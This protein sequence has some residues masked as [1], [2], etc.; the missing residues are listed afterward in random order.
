MPTKATYFEKNTKNNEILFAQI[1]LVPQ[2][3]IY[4]CEIFKLSCSETTNINS[5]LIRYEGEFRN[6]LSQLT[7]EEVS[8]ETLDEL[9]FNNIQEKI[10]T[11]NFYQID[12]IRFN[13][14]LQIWL[15][16]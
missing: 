2:K 12:K 5:L 13:K 3:A 7:K 14:L 1:Y 10:I 11:Q 8:S 15:L 9:E 16:V 6:I 4:F